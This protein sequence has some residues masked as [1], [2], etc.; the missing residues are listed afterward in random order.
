MA[1]QHLVPDNMGILKVR[2]YFYLLALL[3][4]KRG[5]PFSA[6]TSRSVKRLAVFSLLKRERFRAVSCLKLAKK[7]KDRRFHVKPILLGR[8]M[9]GAWYSL[10]PEM[11]EFDHEEFFNFM[12][13][14]PDSFDWLLD[15]VSPIITKKSLREPICPGER[16][17]VTLRYLASGDSMV[18]LSYLFRISDQTISNIVL[19][20]TAAI[21]FV[22]KGEVFEPLS[23]DMWRRKSAEFESLW[24]FP[25]CVG[26]VDGKHCFVQKFPMRGSENFNYKYGHSIILFA[27]SDAKYKFLV[28]DVGARGRESDGGVFD[29]SEFG[30]LFN[31]HQLQ[32]PS[33]VFNDILKTHLPY[34]F[35][36]D[37]AF[38]LDV[39]MLKPFA[40]CL[41][42]KPEE[43]I[44][45]YRLSR[46][47]R[48]VE[49]AFGILAARFRILRRNI[50][51][52]ETLVQNIVL[53]CTALHNLHLIREDSVPPKQRVY[54]PPGY[55]DLY[56]SNGY[57]KRG[58]WRN[59]LK[60][61]ERSIF[62]RLRRQE[63][64]G[65]RIVDGH[66]VREKFLELFV[67]CPLPW[68]YNILPNV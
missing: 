59:E 55:A 29:R 27:V 1:I 23:E 64:H 22:L 2:R 66:A 62:H 11:R 52:S 24:Q 58:R 34:V 7:R 20:T 50:I 17:A 3:R 46:A 37:D 33:P 57:L 25:M 35:V 18:S 19:E 43:A 68:Q 54:L 4:A 60:K 40:D 32:L 15:K 8:K 12:R 65:V 39:H 16:L 56:K 49:N 47:R 53:A 44:F 21:W 9:Y 5:Q 28:V 38:P 67:C 31:N 51:G 14:T 13:M 6:A 36:G 30:K 45:N 42:Q 26:G 10:I 61:E 48:V 41:D 63:E